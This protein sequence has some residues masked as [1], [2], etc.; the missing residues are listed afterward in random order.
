M[1][2]TERFARAKKRAGKFALSQL[3]VP[4]VF[5]EDGRI[6]VSMLSSRIEVVIPKAP[7]M[8]NSD[9]LQLYVNGY[10]DNHA[11]GTPLSLA[12]IDLTDPTITE[13]A[14]YIETP[15][16]P[17][18]GTTTSWVLDYIVFDPF[19]GGGDWSRLPFTIIFDRQTPGGGLLSPLLFTPEQLDGIVLEDLVDGELPALIA[20]WFDEQP[21]DIVELWLGTSDDLIEGAY[22]KEE[23]PVTT[24]GNPVTVS[25]PVAEMEKL[26]N[27]TQ[28][29][30]YR[31]RD[32][33]GNISARSS[34]VRISV[35]LT[36]L[37]GNLL[38]PRIPAYSKGL[39]TYEDVRQLIGVDIPQFT[40]AAVGDRIDV[41]W[42]ST[43][44]PPF[45][46]ANVDPNL[47]PLVTVE[48]PYQE[49]YNAGN[50]RL[51]VKY[52]VWRGG[53]MAATS[54][55]T[56]V[57]VNLD[58]P[59]GPEPDPDPT[60]SENENLKPIEIRSASNALN[61][62]PASDYGLNATAIIHRARV[63]DN[64]PIWLIDDTI[65][66]PW[67][68]DPSNSIGPLL[69][70]NINEPSNISIPVPAALITGVGVGN[71]NV[72]YVI[73]RDLATSPPPI[74]S[75][76]L[77][78]IQVVR[79]VSSASTPGN[80]HLDEAHFPAA[81]A[82]NVITRAA[83]FNGT[84]FQIPLRGVAHV[85]SGNKINY[86]FVGIASG[87]DPA[88]PLN[89]PEIPGTIITDPDYRISINDMTAGYHEVMISAQIMRAICRGG[90]FVIYTITND[91]GPTVADRRFVRIA[92][93]A[94]GGSCEIR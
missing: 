63:A 7:E 55:Q 64:Q 73:N 10:G 52:E 3:R 82:N 29:F 17:P 9:T 4:G 78:P 90:A 49:V 85:I 34:T 33:V 43:R 46:L 28:Y 69:I 62:I 45:T 1:K 23:A 38:A 51:P 59:G 53:V 47:N 6:P 15:D 61:F 11:Y 60:T 87:D 74:F 54:P 76:A 32:K 75:P 27:V 37:P 86:R 21:G 50:G 65:T 58:T 18:E 25:F 83:G 5:P 88:P 41:I 14:L 39:V 93:N 80:G 16:F 48:L 42:G 66:I 94:A 30:A 24:P 22:I 89:T 68:D 57:E 8:Q 35:S 26:G 91:A 67:G 13:F 84:T 2:T 77:S 92:V 71:I 40:N 81:N 70:D 79:V 44:M 56:F 19:S 36:R 31:V 20:P 72:T 12:G